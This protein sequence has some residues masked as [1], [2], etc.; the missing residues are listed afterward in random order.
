MKIYRRIKPFWRDTK[1]VMTSLFDGEVPI[2]SVI[3][4]TS[5]KGSVR[6]NHYHKK[7]SHYSY[8]VSGSMEY[9][10]WPRP[11]HRGRKERA[12]IK[13]GDMVYTPAMRLHQMRFLADSVFL[14]LATKSRKQGA[15]EDDTVR[16]T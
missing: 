2:R 16:I 3:L 9:A 6:A 8:I 12:I 11:G 10:E 5:K 15:Y 14:V 1:G 4:I 13:A 7:D